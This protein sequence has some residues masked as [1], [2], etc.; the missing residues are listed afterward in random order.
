[1]PHLII[2]YSANLRERLALPSLIERMHATALETGV[3]PIGGLRT[4]AAER[5]HY[6]IADGHPANGF[7]HVTAR[8][9]HGRDAPTRMRAATMLFDALCA[10]LQPLFEDSPLGISFEVQELDPVLNFKKNNLHDCVKART[11]GKERP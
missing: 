3:F 8:I 7:V 6:R 9:G 11:A 1:M 5:E 10:Q 2:E 4:R